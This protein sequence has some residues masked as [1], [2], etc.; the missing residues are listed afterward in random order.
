[1]IRYH[2]WNIN[3][4]MALFD[5]DNTLL[6]G[7]SDYFWGKF[8]V[9]QKLVDK[10]TYEQANQR[11]YQ[12][13]QDGCLDIEAFLNF[14]LQPLTAYSLEFLT[15]L[16]QQF[17]HEVIT[18]LIT[19]AALSLVEQHHQAGDTTI[20]I[21]ATNRFV[22]ENIAKQFAID[23]LIATDPEMIDGQ[24]TGKVA[25]LPCFKEG[26]VTRLNDWLAKNNQNLDD[27]WFYSDSM[28]DLPLLEA[29][30]HPVATHPDEKL[31]AKAKAMGWPVISLR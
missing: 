22:T 15:K 12:E 2:F 5:L 4:A 14:S 10:Q 6:N 8:L 18:P 16:H 25:G 11:F 28:N 30:T 13:Y 7:D 19:P 31:Q 20:I 26:K 24:Y 29:V 9:D 27:S 23:D 17:M 3:M 21:T 1:M